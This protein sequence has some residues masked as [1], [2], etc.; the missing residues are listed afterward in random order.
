MKMTMMHEDDD[1]LPQVLREARTYQ[2]QMNE[3]L[4]EKLAVPEKIR[5]LE[6]QIDIARTD[7]DQTKKALSEARVN[8]ILLSLL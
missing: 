6:E 3:A 1:A 4:K 2:D 8:S 7:R 5:E